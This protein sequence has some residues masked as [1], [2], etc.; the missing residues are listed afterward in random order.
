[1]KNTSVFFME[2]QPN[3]IVILEIPRGHLEDMPAIARRAGPG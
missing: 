2:K 3:H 1:M